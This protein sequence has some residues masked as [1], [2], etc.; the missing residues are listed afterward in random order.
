MKLKKALFL[1]VH[2]NALMLQKVLGRYVPP[3][4]KGSP[5]QIFTIRMS[6]ELKFCQSWD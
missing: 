2:I 1:K 6:E 4:L 3:R 5:E